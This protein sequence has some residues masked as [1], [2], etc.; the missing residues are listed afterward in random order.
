LNDEIKKK[1]NFE[2]VP[3]ARKKRNQKNKQNDK[4]NLFFRRATQI[5]N[6]GE[7]KEK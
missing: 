1:I 2:E 7:R 3:K 6:K 5:L 4:I